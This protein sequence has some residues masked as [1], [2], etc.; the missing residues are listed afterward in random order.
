MTFAYAPFSLWFIPF[1]SLPLIFFLH[2]RYALSGFKSGFF[3]GLG[4][5]GA[6]I[7]WV[8]V[9][10]ANF[11]GLPLLGSLALMALL[12]AYLSLFPAGALWL[13]QKFSPTKYQILVITACWFLFEWLRSWFLTGFPWLS[14]GYTQST[15]PLAGWYP[16][17]GETGVSAL[18]LVTGCL[19]GKLVAPSHQTKQQKAKPIA[20]S[21]LF[22]TLSTLLASSFTFTE[23]QPEVVNIAMAQGN[24][25]Q[26]LRWVPEQ[27]EPTMQKY[28][29]LSENLW[30]NDVIL[31]PEAAIPKLEP[32]ATRYLQE[33][34]QLAFETNTGLITGIVNYNF[35]TYEAFNNLIVL[36][37]AAQDATGPEYQYF[38]QNRYSKHHL[39]PVGEFIPMEDWLRGLAP[40]F[41]LPMSS[42]SRGAY[43]QPNLLVNGHHFVAAICFEIAFPR[44][45]QANLRQKSDFLL[46]VSNDA[47]F[48]DSHGPAQHLEIAQVRAAEFGLPL[49]RATNN[50][51]TAYVDHHGKVIAQAPQFSS[52][53]LEVAL[54]K[55]SGMTAY[56]YW[57]DMPLWLFTIVT[58]G[59]ATIATK[60]QRRTHS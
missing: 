16:V 37:K 31:W 20:V 49:I 9:S 26:E 59:F 48:G 43:E 56:R 42:F 1:I 60:R 22:L 58:L 7:S 27:D 47:W 32:L 45:I 41:D 25:K 36:G 8:H 44:Q 5:F 2:F 11:G 39:L 57:G 54:H 18:L 10:I 23:K 4:W 13:S 55:V 53:T 35:E 52:A 21:L 17:I 3:F 34:D 51:I 12:V 50:G 14:L 28:L 46:T 24:I 38:H 40:I 33:L 15:S 19:L 29:A 30:H 6:G